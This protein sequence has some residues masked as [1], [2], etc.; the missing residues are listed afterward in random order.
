MAVIVVNQQVLSGINAITG[1]WGHNP[2]PWPQADE[3]PGP[4]CYC[5]RRGC[6]ETFL[7]GPAMA[8]NFQNGVSATHIAQRATQGDAA[9]Q[10]YLACYIDRLA[11][12]LS[13][14]DQHT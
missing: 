14:C 9:S 7:S 8:Q 6:I 1:E 4:E 11:R 13:K 2:L 5:G 3:L 10:Q 12:Q